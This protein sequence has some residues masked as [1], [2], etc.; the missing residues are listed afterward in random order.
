MYRL[1]AFAMR[2]QVVLLVYR[3]ILLVNIFICIVSTSFLVVALL[4][5][6]CVCATFL[7]PHF[8]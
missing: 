5:V 3:I 1:L 7:Y 8:K 4:V 2:R 6:L